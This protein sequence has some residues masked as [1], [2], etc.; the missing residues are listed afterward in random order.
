MGQKEIGL[1]VHVPFCKAKCHYCDF[2]SFADKNELQERYVNC[3]QKEIIKYASENKIMSKHKKEELYILKTIYIG[4]GTPSI[5]TSDYIESIL[6]TIKENFKIVPNAEI[7]IEVN[8]GTV[9]KEK[10]EKYK[11]LGINRLS[12]GL[13]TAQDNLLKEIGRIHTYSDFLG[14]IKNARNIGFDNINVDLMIGLPS[15]TMEDVEDTLKRVLYFRPEHLSVYSLILEENTLL[16]EMVEN[17]TA[18]LP[19]D[20][21]ERRMYWYVKNTLENCGYKQYEISNYAKPG[22]ESRHNLAC[23][24]QNEYI[25]VGVNASSFLKRQRYS[26]V[27]NIEEYIKNIEQEEINKNFVL[28][29]NLSEEEKKKEFMLLALRKVEGVSISEYQREFSTNPIMEYCFQLDKLVNEGLIVV[30]DDYIRLTKKGL[31][32]ANLVW[33]EFV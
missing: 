8:P 6:N 16:K 31:D 1:Y 26:N 3:L 24:N 17:K 30:E 15:Q 7:T 27:S 2:V 12:I 4:G 13:Q 21:A 33:E 14:T 23:W 10:L 19:S 5:L 20:D 9:D 25:G 29:E 32:F 18:M 22:F 11:E 28:E